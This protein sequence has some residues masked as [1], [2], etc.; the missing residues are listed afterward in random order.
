MATITTIPIACDELSLIQAY[1][2]AGTGATCWFQGV[3]G[4]NA[5]IVKME[6]AATPQNPSPLKNVDKIQSEDVSYASLT[7]SGTSWITYTIPAAGITVAV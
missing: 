6:I 5:I 2:D 1:E 7:L 4:S 3:F